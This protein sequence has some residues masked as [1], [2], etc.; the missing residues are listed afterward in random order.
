[1]SVL[2]AGKQALRRD[3][4]PGGPRLLLTDRALVLLLAVSQS[5]V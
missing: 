4:G 3:G 5:L 1:M 2:G